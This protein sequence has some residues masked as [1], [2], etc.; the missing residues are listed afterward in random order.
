MA[1][2]SAASLAATRLVY[3][4]AQLQQ[5]RSQALQYISLYYW[6]Y[7]FFLYRETGTALEG[8]FK[9]AA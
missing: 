9:R 8:R 1:C 5:A 3:R 4:R 6:F 7:I 2:F